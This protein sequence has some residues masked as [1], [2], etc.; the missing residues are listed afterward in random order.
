MCI[1]A[2]FSGNKSVPLYEKLTS[3][4][5]KYSLLFYFRNKTALAFLTLEMSVL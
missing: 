4:Q 5:I 1:G 2:F 3:Q